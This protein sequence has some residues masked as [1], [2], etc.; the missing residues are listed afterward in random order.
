MKNKELKI[1]RKKLD[2]LD[3]KNLSLIK[4]RTSLVNQVIKIKKYKSQIVDKKR[5][6]EVLKKIR[7]NSTK[8]KI[9]PRITEKIWKSMIASYIEYERR[10]FKAKNK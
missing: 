3:L 9:D 2:K 8:K 4:K 10:K 6:K 1:V 7:L 5:I